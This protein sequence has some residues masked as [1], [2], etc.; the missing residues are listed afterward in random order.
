MADYL[1][2]HNSPDLGITPTI[3]PNVEKAGNF[4][5]LKVTPSIRRIDVGLKSQ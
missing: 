5:R 2:P 3:P 4:I 1:I